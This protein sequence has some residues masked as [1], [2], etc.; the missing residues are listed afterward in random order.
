[1]YEVDEGNMSFNDLI[2]Y[3]VLFIVGFVVWA[4]ARRI[5]LPHLRVFTYALP[6]WRLWIPITMGFVVVMS[7][8]FTVV[9]VL[10]IVAYFIWL[11]IK[12]VIPWPIKPILLSIPP[13]P[14]LERTGIFGL[15]GAFLNIFFGEGG[16]KKFF[17]RILKFWDT[18]ARFVVG[19]GDMI[20]AALRG[21]KKT[22]S[23]YSSEGGLNISQD[24]IRGGE[25]RPPP[26]F[27]KT[28]DHTADDVYQQCMEE[29]VI[30]ITYDMSK[31]DQRKAESKNKLNQTLCK[32]K[33]MQAYMRMMEFKVG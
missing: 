9:L 1:M 33:K 15:I 19:N 22:K 13:F 16:A 21:E 17:D 6:P 2:F 29:N 26:V 32:A 7:M 11:F 5:R 30:K 31:S 24:P 28:D 18:A 10:L 14:Q 4:I 8:I 20:V 3:A 12:K 25:K 27:E 23:S